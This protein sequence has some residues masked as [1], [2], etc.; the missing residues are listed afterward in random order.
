M[1]QGQIASLKGGKDKRNSK[2]VGASETSG[3][4]AECRRLQQK[5]LNILGLL[6]RKGWPQCHKESS[7]QVC[8]SRLYQKKKEQS[9]LS[10][11]PDREMKGGREPLLDEKKGVR[12]GACGGRN[13]FY[14]EGRQV[15]KK[16]GEQPKKASLEEVDGN[17]AGKW[18][19]NSSGGSG[20][21]WFHFRSGQTGNEEGSLKTK[22]PLIKWQSK[23]SRGYSKGGREVSEKKVR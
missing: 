23:M 19:Q 3:D 2:F 10:R 9:H 15:P 6:K 16:K 13:K 14:S 7:R 21:Y 18:T 17:W 1:C 4:L 22:G 20:E 12:A 8:Q 11:S 5:N